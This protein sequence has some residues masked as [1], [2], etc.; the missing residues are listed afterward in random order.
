MSAIGICSK[1]GVFKP[2][3]SLLERLPKIQR[4]YLSA[5]TYHKIRS[6]LSTGT[7][8]D[9]TCDDNESWMRFSVNVRC[10]FS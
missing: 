5:H 3:I 4:Y 2:H 7:I 9:P 10:G 6:T 1:T 8:P